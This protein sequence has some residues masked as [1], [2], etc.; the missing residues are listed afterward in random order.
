[1]TTSAKFLYAIVMVFLIFSCKN[2]LEEQE[3]VEAN[4]ESDWVRVGPGGGGSTFL[5]TFSYSSID[6]FF[7]KCDMTGVYLTRDGGNTYAQINNPSGSYSFAF[8]PRD[9]ETLYVGSKA[10]N[11][12]SDGGKSWNIIFPAKDEVL[13]EVFIGDYADFNLVTTKNSLYNQTVNEKKGL[14]VETNN[15]DIYNI[16]VDP[17]DSKIIYFSSGSNFFYTTDAG[18]SWSSLEINGTIDYIYTNTTNAKEKVYLFTGSNVSIVDKNSWQF[19]SSAFPVKMQPAFSLTGGTLKEDGSTIFYALHS[20]ELPEDS[21]IIRSTSFWVS[22]DFGATWVQNKNSVIINKNG[23]IP[24]YS[25][26]SAAENDAANVY[27]VTSSYQERKKDGEIAHWFGAIKSSDAS[28]NW[29]W[30]WKGGGGSG[31][32]GS[33]DGNDATNLSDAWVQKAF[34]EDFIKLLDVGVAPNDGNV[35]IVTDWYRSM[36]TKDGGETWASIYS[37][38]QSDGSYISN[39]LDVTTTYG[40]HFDPHDSTHLA[41]SYT[42]IG[43][44]HSFNGG[45]SWLRSVAGIPVDWQNTCYWMVF[46]PKISGKVWSVWSGLH[47]FP[48]G[49]MTRN[50]KWNEHARGGVAVSVDGGKSWAPTTKGIGFDSPS[51]SIVLDDNSPVG[52]RTLYVTAY[53]K[54]VFKSVD[55]GNTWELRNNGIAG[56][57]AAFELTIQEDGTLFLITSPT[58]KHENG[59]NR[60][61]VFMGAVYKSI[62]GA[63]SWQKLKIGNDTNF[64]SGLTFDPKNPNIIF[65]GSWADIY[66]SDLVGKAVTKVT[67]GNKRLDFDGGIR[68]SEDGGNSWKQIFDKDQYVYDVTRRYITC[69]SHVLQHLQSRGLSK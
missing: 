47:D 51:T 10:L 52:N 14:S 62:D 32:Y 18:V 50:S 69:W 48:R 7:I 45:K 39:G 55:D 38:Q 21:D 44:H 43:Y 15:L 56:S 25:A 64:P 53:G 27:I 66:L 68:M 65:L 57:L 23:V 58:P 61:D 34:G 29:E 36:K 17:N 40:V 63:G 49:K 54:G 31:E 8:D 41:I 33:R 13:D 28:I 1:M 19:T 46:D 2:N 4:S 9:S 16:K 12:S 6:Y 60:R 35:A 42:D 26:L 37:T 5:P 22:K 24:T 30:V 20:N 3:E 11:K 67:G 59:K